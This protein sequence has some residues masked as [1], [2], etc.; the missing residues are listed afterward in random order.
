M[1]A[2]LLSGNPILAVVNSD[3]LTWDKKS[4]HPWILQ[5]IMEYEGSSNH[6]LPPPEY[7]PFL[8]DLEDEI[9]SK[10]IDTEGYLHVGR[11]TAENRR[12]VFF[13][14][15]EFRKP[16]KVLAEIEKKYNGLVSYHIFKDKYWH[17]F[18]QFNRAKE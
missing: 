7:L 12:E 17:S 1:E 11:Q 9:L 8:Q 3:L 5:V 6:G 16:S 2:Q 14:C 4:S 15:K 18:L 13:A 10:L